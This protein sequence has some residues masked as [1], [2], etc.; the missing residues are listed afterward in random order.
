[1]LEKYNY[2]GKNKEEILE[3]IKKELNLELDELFLNEIEIEAKL[4][5]S[6]KYKIEVI[7][8]NDLIKFIKNYL[9]E[10]QELFGLTINS[11]VTIK[12]DGLNVILVSENNAILI[13]KDG[14][15]LTSLQLLIKQLVKKM[16]GVNYRVNVDVGGYK[17]KK[18]STLEYQIKFIAKDVLRT[19]IEVKLDPMNSYERRI[20][21][22]VISEY[23]DLETT[24]EGEEP[25][26]YIVI[27]YKNKE[28]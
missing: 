19:K 12:N 11:E 13:G 17:S 6:K 3:N 14:K 23:L 24:S 5:K 4:F 8:K 26:R 9:K 18:I 21:H 15:T 16:L 7:K 1:M 25:E 2:E 10:L 22:S 27:K 20:V 28:N